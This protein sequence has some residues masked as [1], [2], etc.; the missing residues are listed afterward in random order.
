MLKEAKEEN[1]IPLF[2]S[3]KLTIILKKIITE[4]IAK[5]LLNFVGYP[6]SVSYIDINEEDSKSVTFMPIDR[7][8]RITDSEDYSTMIDEA[9]T[10]RFRQSC[11][12]NIII[13]KII[14]KTFSATDID[15]FYNRFCPEVDTK[16][17][18][19]KRFEIVR[20]EDIRYWY[21]GTRWESSL[22]SCMQSKEA[23]K[24]LDIY[25][26]NPEKCGLLIYYSENT[27]KTIVGRAL[28]W[29]NL[30]KP[31]GDT[32]EDRTPYTFMDRVYFINASSQIPATFKKY[33]IDN[34]WI[35][36]DNDKFLMN[37]L[38]KTRTLATRLKPVEYDYYPY[39]DTMCYYTPG[40]GRAASDIGS[41]AKA[42]PTYHCSKRCENTKIYFTDGNCPVCGKKL[43]EE[44]PKFETYP[45][46]QLR[47]QTGG[48]L[49]CYNNNVL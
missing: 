48:K 9:W 43:N 7:M 23:Q 41:P 20:G 10:S 1:K 18:G 29:N 15:R 31:S 25:V 12:W 35:Y 38:Q 19:L 32:I 27:R 47:T 17:E 30:T 26:N 36:K 42:I 8:N 13:N 3:P 28:V 45:R 6:V 34:G 39:V 24:Y 16:E 46:Y 21:L 4:P 5:A 40:T 22:T 37:G 49:Y 2:I 11:G 33:A 44:K 14:P